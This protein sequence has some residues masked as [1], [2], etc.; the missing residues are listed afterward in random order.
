M[1]KTIVRNVSNEKNLGRIAGDFVRQS[2]A[3]MSK[4]EFDDAVAYM[5]M[6]LQ[7]I[8]PPSENLHK[9]AMLKCM[10]YNSQ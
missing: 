9:A 5:K 3:T 6:R 4:E 7:G 2:K 10:G 1:I 8:N